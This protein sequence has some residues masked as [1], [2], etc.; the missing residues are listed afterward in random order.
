MVNVK[1]LCDDKFDSNLT[2]QIEGETVADY[3]ADACERCEHY[4]SCQGWAKIFD[5]CG[6]AK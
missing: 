4:E 2:Y 1:I 6:G 3:H 5:R